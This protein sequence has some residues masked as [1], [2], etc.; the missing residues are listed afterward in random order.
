MQWNRDDLF[1]I[2]LAE[3]NSNVIGSKL[4]RK[5]VRKGSN[6]RAFGLSRNILFLW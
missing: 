2:V 5:G 3:E 1:V 4:R 6:V